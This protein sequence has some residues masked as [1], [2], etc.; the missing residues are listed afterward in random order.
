MYNQRL[1]RRNQHSPLTISVC[2]LLAIALLSRPAYPQNIRLITPIESTS[3]SFTILESADFDSSIFTQG[4]DLEGGRFY[5]SGGQYGR[6]AI[7][8]ESVDGK[9]IISQALS[10]KLFAEGLVKYKNS[11][12][13]L[14]WRAGLLA[15]FNAHTLDHEATFR[16]SGQG[17]GLTE[18]DGELV[19]S[20]GSA[21]LSFHT[22]EDFSLLRYIEV[23]DNA[24]A[25]TQLNELE[26]AKGHIWANVW[27]SDVIY[28]IDPKSG[29][30]VQKYDL[31]SLR[32]TLQLH[33]SEAVLN[34][35]AYDKER[36]A[37][38]ITGKLWPKRFLIQF[39]SAK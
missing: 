1:T 12:Y 27:H 29:V 3:K 2:V 23:K 32:T 10:S 34:G 6:S 37:F 18:I 17:W 22:P 38:W 16:Y 24:R 31:S 9:R 8:V 28:K 35:I 33:N 14:T 15:K 25:V 4:L 20:N 30:V 5:I 7:Y 11:L 39:H 13:L 36:E 26:Y 19:K 21:R